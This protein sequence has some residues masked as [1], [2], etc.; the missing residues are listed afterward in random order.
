MLEPV[1][2]GQRPLD[3]LVQRLPVEAGD[4]G[5][6]AAVVVVLGADEPERARAAVGGR[7]LGKGSVVLGRGIHGCSG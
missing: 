5:D 2:R 4:A 7:C 1:E 3:H 6:P